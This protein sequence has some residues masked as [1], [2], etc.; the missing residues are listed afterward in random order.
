MLCQNCGKEL[1]DGAGFCTECGAKVAETGTAEIHTDMTEE[2]E[3]N[4]TVSESETP[5]GETAP[6]EEGQSEEHKETFR[7][8]Y[9]SFHGRL[10]RKRYF[11]RMLLLFPLEILGVLLTEDIAFSVN[12]LQNY[13]ITY[14]VVCILLTCIFLVLSTSL[15]VRRL[16]DLNLH[17]WLIVP[18]YVISLFFP[19]VHT[20]VDGCFLFHKGTEGPNKYGPDPLAK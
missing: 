7:E 19:I 3:N 17:G 5:A 16:H 12:F 8:K 6:V 4:V 13:P 15:S 18:I 14:N 10:N 9:L 1:P 11:F 20:V 2:T